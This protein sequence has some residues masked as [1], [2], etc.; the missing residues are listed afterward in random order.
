MHPN[1]A[2]QHEGGK[3]L[4]SRELN[5]STREQFEPL[6]TDPRM[7][8]QYTGPTIVPPPET[9]KTPFIMNMFNAFKWEL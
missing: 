7:F 9:A 5:A 2:K 8:R 6:L 3:Q 1:E 4:F